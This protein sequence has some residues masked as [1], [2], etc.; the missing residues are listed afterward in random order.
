[1][2]LR[3]HVLPRRHLDLLAAGEGGRDT[4]GVLW[5]GERSRRLL[6]L[7][8]L[9]DEVSRRP[10]LLEPLAPLD[11]AWTVLV[12]VQQADPAAFTDVLMSPPLGTWL[13]RM[14]RLLHGRTGR[15]EPLWVELG[16]LHAAAFAAAHRARIPCSTRLPAGRGGVFLPTLGLARFPGAP[17]WNM[18]EAETMDGHAW[19]WCDGQKVVVPG[20]PATDAT[21][22]WPLRRLT[23]TAGD[24]VLDVAI[25]DLDPYRD[26][27]DP[28]PTA[29]LGAIEMEGWR[30]V[31]KDAWRLLD[32]RWPAAAEAM[33]AGLVSLAPLPGDKRETRSASSGDAFGAALIS[34]LDDPVTLAATLVHEFQ[35]IKLGGLLHLAPLLSERAD[36]VIG[37][38]PWRDD[39]RPLDGLLQGVYAFAGIAEFFGRYRMSAPG[40]EQA[41]ADFEFAYARRQARHG[42]TTLLRSA[43]LTD[44][45]RRFALGLAA[46]ARAQAR[47]HVPLPAGR[48]AWAA[49][50]EH[51]AAW[52]IRHLTPDPDRVR[53]LAAAFLAGR[54]ARAA[55][56]V[57][58]RLVPGPG[59]RWHSS[60]L[61]LHRLRLYA[62][63]RYRAVALDQAPLPAAAQG[64]VRSDL[65]LV[66][67]SPAVAESGYRAMI[68]T[69]PGDLTAWTGL[70]IATGI[71]RST[72]AWRLLIRRPEFVRAVYL[73]VAG[74]RT[75]VSPTRVAEWLDTGPPPSDGAR[76]TP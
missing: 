7:R 8:A 74:R 47:R 35:H 34:R 57:R 22:W 76:T 41:L 53:H 70:V 55:A 66:G 42:L 11:D 37:Y 56:T 39:P 13:S 10:A 3:N 43:L 33:S 50:I 28:V 2:R 29:R 72:S 20:D 12:A 30:T 75:A 60:R 51:E 5:A 52:R 68:A 38:A 16:Y 48:A 36:K 9:L 15:Q 71:T 19:V 24:R 27:A 64:A 44:L 63:D 4:I 18:A 14:T 73:A 17:V 1:M 69:E 49:A 62:P 45:G 31:L 59:E 6:L 61:P 54:P 21:N 25:D 46:Q 26:L 40:P 23:T 32:D 65:A 67:G 58:S